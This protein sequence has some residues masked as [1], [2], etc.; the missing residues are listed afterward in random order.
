MNAAHF[1]SAKALLPPLKRGA[2]SVLLAILHFRFCGGALVIA[3]SIPIFRL[4]CERIFG[5]VFVQK[6]ERLP[7]KPRSVRIIAAIPCGPNYQIKRLG[8]TCVIMPGLGPSQTFLR[9]V[10]RRR[11]RGTQRG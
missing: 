9:E 1:R 8:H 7:R 2:T 10:I 4:S 6:N 11:I 3:E 5:I